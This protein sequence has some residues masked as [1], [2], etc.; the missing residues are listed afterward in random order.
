MTLVPG[1]PENSP[2]LKPIEMIWGILKRRIA[3]YN[4]GAADFA[5]RLTEL[6][7]ELDQIVI[8]SL[9]D[10]CYKRCELVLRVDGA[11]LTP[12]LQAHRS[13]PPTV[14]RYTRYWCDEDDERFLLLWEEHGP[15]WTLIAWIAGEEPY[16]VKYRVNRAHQIA[17][18]NGN[19]DR[20]QLQT[21][22]T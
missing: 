17:V 15:K 3:G 22:P 6:W 21:S 18:K 19:P 20:V 12:Y 13:G 9:V 4:C 14:I 2:D 16:F 1:W 10:S 11:S 5:R 8:N 7:L